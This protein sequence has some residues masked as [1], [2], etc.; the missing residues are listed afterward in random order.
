VTPHIAF[1]TKETIEGILQTTGANIQAFQNGQ[2][3]NVV[4]NP[5]IVMPERKA[6]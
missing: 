6:V 2:A 1:Y 5:Q 4:N 3:R